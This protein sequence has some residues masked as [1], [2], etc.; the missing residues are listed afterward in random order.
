M[1]HQTSMADLVTPHF[2]AS[3]AMVEAL[4]FWE[5]IFVMYVLLLPSFMLQL[6]IEVF[7]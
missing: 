4:I 5:T 3:D 2:F 1:T 7:C 6:L